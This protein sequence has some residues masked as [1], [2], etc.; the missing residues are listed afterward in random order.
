MKTISIKIINKIKMCDLRIFEA[1]DDD[2]PN[3]RQ[4]RQNER[5]LDQYLKSYTQEEKQELLSNIKWYD[6][7]CKE[8]LKELGWIIK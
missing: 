5:A 2:P 4:V 1:Q 7:N 8:R 6:D 3:L